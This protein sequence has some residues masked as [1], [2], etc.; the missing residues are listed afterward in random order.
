[1]KTILIHIGS[2]KA[3]GAE[4]SLISLLNCLPKDQYNIDVLVFNQTGLF[5]QLVPTHVNV[6]EADF[7]YKYLNIP[8]SNIKSY[9]K[10]PIIIF[11]KI[12]SYLLSTQNKELAIQQSIWNQWRNSIPPMK[13]DYDIAISYLE[14][15]TNYF[16]IEKV[17]ANKKIIWVHNEY[18]KLNY[19][20]DYDLKYFKQADKIITISETCES[21]LKE[22]FPSLSSKIQV[23]ANISDEKLI[24]KLAETKEEDENFNPSLSCLKLLTIGRFTPQKNYP[25]LLDTAKELQDR[26]VNFKWFIIGD[27]PLKKD[28]IKK[29]QSLNLN[30]KVYLLGLKSNPYYFM[31]QSDIIVQTSLFEGKSIVLDEAKILC[32]PIVST[33]YPTVYDAIKDKETG[34]ISKM[35]ATSLSE[36]II[37]LATSDLFRKIPQNLQS[38]T[39]NNLTEINNY[40]KILEE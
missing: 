39:T 32:K 30:D 16:I 10:A 7:P 37:K 15:I 28:I 27:G 29:I 22:N 2:F 3:G 33:D 31:K 36:D 21:D 12:K 17:K 5:S 11:K 24:K 38:T 23:L 19:N 4:K 14:G 34:I 8:I 6:I 13:K 25:L 1:M 35:N 18:N 9:I 20:K 26:N 40:I